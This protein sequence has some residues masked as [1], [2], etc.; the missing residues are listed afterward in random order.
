MNEKIIYFHIGFPKTASS[1]LQ[2]K[3]FFKNKKLNY[4]GIPEKKNWIKDDWY[5]YNFLL[6]LFSSNN[7]NFYSNLSTHLKNLEK[8]NIPLNKINIIS[9]DSLT[10][11]MYLNNFDIFESLKR[12][13]FIFEEKLNF[14]IKILL[15]IRKQSEMI[16]SFYSQFYRLLIKIDNKWKKF[17]NFLKTFELLQNDNI[18]NEKNIYLKI[19]TNFKYY[20]YYNFLEKNFKTTNIKILMYE[21]LLFNPDFYFQEINDFFEVDY[22]LLEKSLKKDINKSNKIDEN[23]YERKFIPIHKTIKKYIK[24]NKINKIIYRLLTADRVILN[25]YS[26]DLI[27]KYYLEDNKRMDKVLYGRLKRYKY[28]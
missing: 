23:E 16:L 17:S 9:H 4:L 6:F 27:N 8:I 13:K 14:K 26:K 18:I 11:P 3:V 28:F 10:N 2:S 19:F 24:D 7:D 15:S 21:D 5:L 22:L 1:F 20:N 12:I 25:N